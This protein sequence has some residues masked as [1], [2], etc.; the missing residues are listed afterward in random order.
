V[1]AVEG[2][3]YGFLGAEEIIGG[4]MNEVREEDL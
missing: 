2:P 1:K 4:Y 3:E